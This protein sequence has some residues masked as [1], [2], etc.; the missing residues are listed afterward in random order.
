MEN[1]SFLH[2]MMEGMDAGMEVMLTFRESAIT[3]SVIK[4]MRERVVTISRVTYVDGEY[5]PKSLFEL[6]SELEQ[7]V[8]HLTYGVDHDVI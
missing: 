4:G 7:V 6:Q 1:Y 3:V 8:R 5:F 2:S